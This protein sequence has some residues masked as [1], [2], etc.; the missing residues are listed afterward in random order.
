MFRET[1]PGALQNHPSM[2]IVSSYHFGNL[3]V[4]F[5][6]SIIREG[7]KVMIEFKTEIAFWFFPLAVVNAASKFN[8]VSLQSFEA[9]ENQ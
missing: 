5:T 3:R 8:N 2:N 4:L 1:P 6:N 7:V 9:C